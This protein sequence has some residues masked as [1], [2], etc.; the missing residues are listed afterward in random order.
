MLFYISHSYAENAKN[1]RFLTKPDK[2]TIEIKRVPWVKDILRPLKEFKIGKKYCLHGSKNW[3]DKC[4]DAAM[5]YAFGPPWREIKHVIL[6]F[7]ELSKKDDIEGLEKLVS[8][9][10]CLSKAFTKNG[11]IMYIGT[12]AYNND[13]ELKELLSKA[14]NV[15]R[16]YGVGCKYKDFL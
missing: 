7:I 11:D 13:H 12:T 16:K 9:P 3:D 4:Q 6:E 8:L 2:K 10:F 5:E 15:I 14:A 1:L